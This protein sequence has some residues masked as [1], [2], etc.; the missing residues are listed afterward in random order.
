LLLVIDA[1]DD[2]DLS[3]VGPV[4]PDG[5]KCWPS[6][7]DTSWHMRHVQDDKAGLVAFIAGYTDTWAATWSLSR[8]VNSEGRSATGAA[9]DQILRLAVALRLIRHKA[10]RGIRRIPE[11]ELVKKVA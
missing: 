4:W 6:A 1:F 2:I 9:A 7:A 5:P 3:L 8:V 10:V 11:R